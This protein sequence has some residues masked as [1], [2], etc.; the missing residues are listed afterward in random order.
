ML[1]EHKR[2][3]YKLFGSGNFIFYDQYSYGVIVNPWNGVIKSVRQPADMT[4]LQTLS[5][6]ADPSHYGVIG[7][8]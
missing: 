6:L 3:T 8:I 1:S 2:D 7:G 4:I 5:H